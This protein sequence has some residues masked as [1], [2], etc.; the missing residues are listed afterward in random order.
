MTRGN[1]LAYAVPKWLSNP[2]GSYLVARLST[3]SLWP[4]VMFAESIDGLEV[5]EFVP[6]KPR[7][8]LLGFLS[9]I[10]FKGRVRK[11]T[12]EK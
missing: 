12:G 11:G 1:C 3:H 10:W 9:A 8:G 5:E 7:R 6:V 2:R 4:H